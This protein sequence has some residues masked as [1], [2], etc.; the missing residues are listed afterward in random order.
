MRVIVGGAGQVLVWMDN[1]TTPDNRRLILSRCVGWC[2]GVM[3]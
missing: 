2:D 3:G 1:T